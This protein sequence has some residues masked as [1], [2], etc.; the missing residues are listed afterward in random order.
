MEEKW[1]QLDLIFSHP[2]IIDKVDKFIYEDSLLSDHKAVA[3]YCPEIFKP[4]EKYLYF[5][6]VID[7]ESYNAIE[8][9]LKSKE[10]IAKLKNSPAWQTFS[11]NEKVFQLQD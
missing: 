2:D 8:L 9:Q 11:H 10:A 6:E 7:W 4:K 3:V 5:E 1:V